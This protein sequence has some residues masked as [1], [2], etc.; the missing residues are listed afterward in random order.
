MKS[1]PHRF[2]VSNLSEQPNDG[3]AK[4]LL[5]LDRKMHGESSM[6]WHHETC[7]ESMPNLLEE[8]RS[9][10]QLLKLHLQKS[11]KKISSGSMDNAKTMEIQKALVV[12]KISQGSSVSLNQS[13]NRLA[14]NLRNNVVWCR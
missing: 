5:D 3:F 11:H 12:L 9:E 2:I 1:N 4:I 13:L 7:D 14:M 10:Q 8:C 6:E